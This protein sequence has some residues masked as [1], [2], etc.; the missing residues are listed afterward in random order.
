MIRR[1]PRSTLFPY[2]TL[3]RSLRSSYRWSFTQIGL[4]TF[5]FQFTAS[6]LQPLVGAFA[7][8]SPRPYS[9][10]SGMGFTL[11]GLVLLAFA[12]SYALLLFAAALIGTGS[13]VFHP[14]SSRVA[15]MAS[16]GKHGLAQSVFQV[17]GNFGTAAGPLPPAFAGRSGE[18]PAA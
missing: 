5:T 9:L 17:G 2:T 16:G 6:L 13:S 10:A 1:P 11:V 18:H 14:E 3:F 15:R 12:D 4:L 7:D 8:K